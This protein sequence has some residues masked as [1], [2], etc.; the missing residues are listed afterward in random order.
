MNTLANSIPQ[1]VDIQELILNTWRNVG[2]SREISKTIGKVI[3][4]VRIAIWDMQKRNNILPPKPVS[5]KNN[6]SKIIIIPIETQTDAQNLIENRKLS[7]LLHNAFP[8]KISEGSSHP[9]FWR[10]WTENEAAKEDAE[11]NSLIVE[12]DVEREEMIANETEG[13]NQLNGSDSL[14]PMPRN[15][16]SHPALS[17]EED[18]END[19]ITNATNAEDQSLN[20]SSLQDDSFRS[21]NNCEISISEQCQ[22]S[23]LEWIVTTTEKSTDS[24]ISDNATEVAANSLENEN[25]SPSL[26]SD[27]SLEI[28]DEKFGATSNGVKNSNLN[29]TGSNDRLEYGKL[30]SHTEI[31]LKQNLMETNNLGNNVCTIIKCRQK[32]SQKSNLEKHKLKHTGEKPFVCAFDNCGHK[33]SRKDRLK[34]HVMRHTCKKQCCEKFPKIVRNLDQY[35]KVSHPEEFLYP[36][37]AEKIGNESLPSLQFLTKHQTPK[38][39]NVPDFEYQTKDF[40][41]LN[42]HKL[43]HTGEKRFKC[44]PNNSKEGNIDNFKL[45]YERFMQSYSHNEN[46]P[47]SDQ[48]NSLEKHNSIQRHA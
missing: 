38:K 48:S 1:L 33:F 40:R 42:N 5:T 31:N 2:N 19:E 17:K 36:K 10:Y 35:L 21:E 44:L 18:I 11:Q 30:F 37:I 9:I 39:R 43:I 15:V 27:S 16:Q 8:K 4:D 6:I 12:S 20:N 26:E 14:I 23:L 24:D 3:E 25:A 13:Q 46:R 28:I 45:L 32:F 34:M 22:D 47:T 7:S 41:N 29:S